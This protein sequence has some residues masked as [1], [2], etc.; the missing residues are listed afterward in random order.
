MSRSRTVVRR[1][2]V[3]AGAVLIGVGLLAPEGAVS[4]QGREP[5]VAVDGVPAAAGDVVS[6]RA[7]DGSAGRSVE[8]F[9]TARRMAA[10]TPADVA[11]LTATAARRAVRR[12]ASDAAGMDPVRS[13][14]TTTFVDLSA[15][16]SADGAR[17]TRGSKWTHPNLLVAKTTGKV[18]FTV[19][20]KRY[21]C[22]G[23]TIEGRRQDVIV[24]AGSCVR[25]RDRWVRNF[26]FV[27][28]YEAGTEPEFG[29]YKAKRY[30]TTSQWYDN[31]D[32]AF[33]VGFVRLYRYKHRHVGFRVGQQGY[34]FGSAGTPFTTAFGYAS[35]N[36]WDGRRLVYCR[37]DSKRLRWMAG[38]SYALR[39]RMRG[40]SV[41][42]PWF[43]HFRK[44]QGRI[45]SVSGIV[46]KD[47][48]AWLGGPYF[49]RTVYRVYKRA[50]HK[51]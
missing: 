47:H 51:G 16:S 27:P 1:R 2:A 48:P 49:G 34:Q 37:N 14:S 12:S 50:E 24:T 33:N 19:R 30:F 21:S 38:D 36:P 25:Y 8:D 9:W 4:A 5:A 20:G 6:R 26:L 23:S 39:C 10:A 17:R 31:H 43:R 40:S 32:P 15:R 45:F 28:G 13:R 46:W 11:P 44:G 35:T 3:V 7:L 42:G 18:F 41:G 22:S 29:I